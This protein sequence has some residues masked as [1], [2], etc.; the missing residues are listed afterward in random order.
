MVRLL[1]ALKSTDTEAVRL[2]SLA[3]LCL[4]AF[5]ALGVLPPLL[6]KLQYGAKY[7]SAHV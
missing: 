3:A 1:G 5:D 2:L 4:G 6:R 7:A